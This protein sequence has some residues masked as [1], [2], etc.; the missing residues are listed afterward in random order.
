RARPVEAA[1]RGR[2]AST[3]PATGSRSR[4][5]AARAKTAVAAGHS[6]LAVVLRLLHDERHPFA[7]LARV[8]QPQPAVRREHAL[9][10]GR[11]DSADDQHTARLHARGDLAG[12][13]HEHAGFDAREHEPETLT[14]VRQPRRPH[15]E[16]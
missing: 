8:E 7:E 11:E 14:Q 5:R 16:T 6:W 10:L 1:A 9:A 2:G 15:L 12:Q 3:P 4:P 13:W